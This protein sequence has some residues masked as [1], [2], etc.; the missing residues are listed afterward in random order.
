MSKRPAAFPIDYGRAWYAEDSEAYIFVE[1]MAT[2][3]GRAV[4]SVRAMRE[5]VSFDDAPFVE[6]SVSRKGQRITVYPVSGDVRIG[7]KP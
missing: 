6:L 4:L 7:D 2:I 5:G 3:D 1:R